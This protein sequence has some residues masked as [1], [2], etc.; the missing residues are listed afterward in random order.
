MAWAGADV[1]LTSRNAA[2]AEATA[3]EIAAATGRRILGIAGDVVDPAAVDAVVAR[4]MH[5]FERIDVLVNSAGIAVR[6]AIDELGRDDFDESMA[7]NVTGSWLMCRA[8]GRPMRDAGY[9]RIVNMASTF[10][11]VGAPNRTAYAASKGAVVQLTR[12][13]AMEWAE[14]GVTV[15]ALA[16]GPFLT[17][18]NIPH[19][20]S[21][22]AIRV[23]GTEV[24][25]KRWGELHE[26]Q[27]AALYL[28]SDASSYVTGSVL[29]VD[30]GWTA[31]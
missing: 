3:V 14:D 27:G 9:G 20:H 25:M 31:H 4:A 11:L 17:A 29:V 13:L 24:A 12:S 21:E 23:I 16:P 28:A 7:V 6:G 26:I 8:V 15:N 5:E 30:G 1:L 22:H 19:Q 18:M 10:G 2:E